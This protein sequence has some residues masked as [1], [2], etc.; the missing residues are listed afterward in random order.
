MLSLF[1]LSCLFVSCQAVGL[2]LASCKQSLEEKESELASL[3]EKVEDR[4]ESG[5]VMERKA[6]AMVSSL[7]L[8]LCCSP[9]QLLLH[10]HGW[11]LW[12][13]AVVCCCTNG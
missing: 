11:L 10:H 5:R 3:V 2:E 4:K 1:L 6:Q 9:K 7:P 13:V 8:H 12:C